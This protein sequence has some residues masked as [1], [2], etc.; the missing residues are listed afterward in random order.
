MVI[1]AIVV[2]VLALLCIGI[3]CALMYFFKK[4][5]VREDTKEKMDAGLFNYL[6]KNGMNDAER[7][8]VEGRMYY[9]SLPKEDVYITSHDGL[10]LHGRYSPLGNGKKVILL[11][12][13]YKSNGEHD[14]SC[15][16]ELYAKRGFDILLIDQRAH[17]E[18]E[19]EYICFGTL[20][21]YDIIRWC[22]YIIGRCGRDVEIVL[23]GI[24]MGCTTVLL[25]A[26]LPEIQEN[27]K[28][29]I[30]DCGFTDAK[31]E[32]SYVAKHDYKLSAFPAVNLLEMVCKR[33]AGYGFSDASTLDAVKNI[34]IPVLFVHGE[35]DSY[36]PC[37]NSRKNYEACASEHKQLLTVPGASHGF[38][39]LVDEKGCREAIENLFAVS[40]KNN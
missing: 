29:V 33:K 7:R 28:C 19:G 20:A 30:G 15:A 31:S 18:S 17:G 1:A 5:F 36:V 13:G 22:E 2:G 6:K 11:A 26:G 39:F 34:K 12:H 35:D 10:R 21:R 37:E 4:S 27:V 32:I 38:S 14:F 24:S 16:F 23:D 40:L 25:A 3:F 8:I 9:R